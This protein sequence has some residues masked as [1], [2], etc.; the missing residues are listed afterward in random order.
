V[1]LDSTIVASIISGGSTVVA[2]V[3]AVVLTAQ[4]QTRRIDT[5]NK[6]AIGRQT[7]EIKAHLTGQ[8]TPADAE[9]E[10]PT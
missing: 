1:T 5:E 10:Q 8:P 2:T 6:L 4:L 7:L 9:S 3:S